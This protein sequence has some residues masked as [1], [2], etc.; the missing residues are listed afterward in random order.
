MT[1]VVVIEREI[2][3]DLLL[4]CTKTKEVDYWGQNLEICSC[5]RAEFRGILA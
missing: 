1:K 3:L 2:A 5:I 4:N